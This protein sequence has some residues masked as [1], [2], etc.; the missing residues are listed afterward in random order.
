MNKENMFRLAVV[1]G[2]SLAKSFK[3]N[4]RKI[5]KLVLFDYYGKSLK[6]SEIIDALYE[7]YTLEFSYDEIKEALKKERGIVVYEEQ[8]ELLSKYTIN[9]KEY[10]KMRDSDHINIDEYIKLFLEEKKS[11][12]EFEELKNLIYRFLYNTFNADKNTVLELM[13]YCD[14]KSVNSVIDTKFD[15]DQSRAINDFLNW[16]YKPK[17]EF[18]LN[19]IASCF[20]YCMLTVKKNTSSFSQI[21]NGKEF[22]LD[23]NVIFRLAGFNNEERKNVMNAFIKKCTGAGIKI[24]YTNHTA[25]EITNT[26]KYH[27]NSLKNALGKNKPLSV[28]AMRIMGSKYANLD[29]YEQYTIWCSMPGN[30]AG[31]FEEFRIY[32]EK[33]VNKILRPFKKIV[34]NKN[35]EGNVKCGFNE[36]VTDFSKYKEEHYRNTYISAIKIDINNYLYMV[37]KNDKGQASNFMDLKYYFITADHCLT[38][39]S[40]EKR[41]GT[42]PIFV[43]PSVWYSILLKYKGRTNDDYKAFCQFLNIRI[44]PEKDKLKDIKERIFPYIMNLNEENEIKEEI[45]Y[46]IERKLSEAN[47]ADENIEEIV[48]ESHKTILESRIAAIESKHNEEMDL[49]KQKIESMQNVSDEKKE[50]SKGQEDIIEKQAEKIVRRRKIISC[51]GLSLL[52]IGIILIV[53]LCVI[54]YVTKDS[55]EINGFIKWCNDNQGLISILIAVIGIIGGSTNTIIAKMDMF[56]TDIEK[57]KKRLRD[58]YKAK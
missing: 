27:V 13:N 29:F 42:I 1:L 10:E 24:C 43:L 23:S 44:A 26:I 56:T 45:I 51:I 30:N 36:L 41:P 46:D 14:S 9:P 8:D 7:I 54:K 12:Y 5:I 22:Y 18:I 19:L 37:D 52:I 15:P 20:E 11:K 6:I 38:E 32:L 33:E 49:L 21:F 3:T 17:N 2:D 25:V 57:V 47:V 16:D 58:K 31:N 40:M 4:L 55:A 50:F 28:K 53:S 48:E 35:Y 34:V 39:W